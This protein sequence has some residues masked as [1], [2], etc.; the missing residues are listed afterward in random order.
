M[1]QY[2]QNNINGIKEVFD[3][4]EI[5]K[6]SYFC[7]LVKNNVKK[8]K[9]LIKST[10][11][12]PNDLHVKLLKE[13]INEQQDLEKNENGQKDILILSNFYKVLSNLKEINKENSGYAK[14]IKEILNAKKGKKVISLKYIQ[15]QY[16]L[17][18]KKYISLMTISRILRHHLKMHFR[19]TIKKNP[20]LLKENYIIMKYGFLIGIMKALDE[21]LN[22]IYIDETGFQNDNNNLYHWRKNSEQIYGGPEA[23][24]KRRINLILAI[25]QSEIILGHYYNNEIITPNEFKSFMKELIDRIGDKKMQ[26]SIFIL[27]NASYH[28][29]RDMKKFYKE[30]KLKILFNCPYKSKFNSIELVFNL[31]KNKLN[32]EIFKTQKDYME[33]I[34]CLINDETIN[35]NIK[36]VFKKTFEKY[37]E[38]YINNIENLKKNKD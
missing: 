15:N 26:N 25:E 33:R 21:K 34:D 28:L 8:I 12:I 20:K 22:L 19:K 32:K 2:S 6:D 11:Y 7:I 9:N 5:S 31:I 1:E 29:S 23:D 38:F 14:K 27:D 30:K 16:K 17:K 4:N 36:K 3:V 37:L 24:I 18:Y 35:N 10:N 13:K